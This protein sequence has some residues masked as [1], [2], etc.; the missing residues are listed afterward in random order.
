MRAAGGFARFAVTM[1]VRRTDTPVVRS[2]RATIVMAQRHTKTRCGGGY[3]LNG[4]RKR[5]REGN[6]Y[7]GDS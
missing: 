7:A 5:Q 1:L 3:R 2:R 6:Q 4:H